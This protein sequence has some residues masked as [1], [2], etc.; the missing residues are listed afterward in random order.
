ML[1]LNL[2][3]N[4]NVLL[5]LSMGI[6]SREIQEKPASAMQKKKIIYLYFLSFY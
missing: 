3:F 6:A 2:R 1:E 4:S 5:R